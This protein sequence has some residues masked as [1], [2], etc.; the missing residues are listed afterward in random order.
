M[1]EC[2]PK[3]P[4]RH[5]TIGLVNRKQKE[6]AFLRYTSNSITLVPYSAFLSGV[7]YIWTSTKGSIR[8][9]SQVGFQSVP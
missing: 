6:G 7:F 9:V 4:G 2:K 5:S 8:L 3:S 1:E